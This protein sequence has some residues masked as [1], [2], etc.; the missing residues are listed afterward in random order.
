[1]SKKKYCRR[2]CVVSELLPARMGKN[3]KPNL[4]NRILVALTSYF[5]NFRRA[6]PALLYWS[7]SL[8]DADGSWTCSGS[9]PFSSWPLKL[10]LSS[11][12]RSMVGV[13]HIRDFKSSFSLTRP[14]LGS[15][16]SCCS[17]KEPAFLRGPDTRERRKSSLS[18]NPS[19]TAKN[20]F[21]VS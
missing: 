14:P 10:K 4:P 19:P 1:M 20:A 6:A 18:P 11:R 3:F 5:Q 13:T 21:Y 7:N 15:I 17:E 16:T 9:G 8:L 2:Y 12:R